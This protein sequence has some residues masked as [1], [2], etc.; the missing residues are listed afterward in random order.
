MTKDQIDKIKKTDTGQRMLNDI[1]EDALLELKPEEIKSRQWKQ[2]EK[3][4]KEQSIK[5][6]KIER[7]IDHF[8]R[9]KRIEEIPLLKQEYEEWK[10]QDREVWAELE[11]ER[12]QQLLAEREQALKHKERLSRMIEDSDKFTEE[13]QKVRHEI[14][15]ARLTDWQK[16]LDEEREG[17]LLQRKQERKQERRRQYILEK[18]RQE[19]KRLAEEA[20]KRKE[21]E[22]AESKRL[23]ELQLKRE[24]FFFV[25]SIH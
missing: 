20:R 7:R 5:Q 16:R 1:G 9:A 18:Q 8:E 11:Q 25:H 14:Y 13:V 3:E 10:V 2:L 6:K 12:I 17:K 4:R 24:Y 22:Y 23:A 21:E 19:A 15:V